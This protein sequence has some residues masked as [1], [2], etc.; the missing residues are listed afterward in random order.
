MTVIKKITAFLASLVVANIVLNT[1]IASAQQL[2]NMF[3]IPTYEHLIEQTQEKE[4]LLA[5]VGVT[6]TG[7]SLWFFANATDFS[8]FFKD[9]VTGQYCT[10]PNYYGMI[11]NPAPTE[12]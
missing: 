6:R 11:L 9:R 12:D 5:F 3:C 10:A 1:S 8:V 7:M 4:L 2:P